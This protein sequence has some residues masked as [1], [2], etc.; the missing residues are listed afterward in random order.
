MQPVNVQRDVRLVALVD[1]EPV[2]RRLPHPG[3]HG[4]LVKRNLGAVALL[5]LA[6]DLQLGIQHLGPFKRDRPDRFDVFLRKQQHAA[7]FRKRG[8]IDPCVHLA[9][10]A[11]PGDPLHIDAVGDLIPRSSCRPLQEIDVQVIPQQLAADGLQKA[12]FR[13]QQRGLRVLP[14]PV[15]VQLNAG[16]VGLDVPAV[17]V[18]HRADDEH[19]RGCRVHPDDL[20]L[21]QDDLPQRVADVLRVHGEHLL[22]LCLFDFSDH[23]A[24]L[25]DR[26]G[27]QRPGFR[28]AHVLAGVRPD[29]ALR[30]GHRDCFHVRL[31]EVAALHD[32][33][34]GGQRCVGALIHPA[35][36][37]LRP[38]PVVRRGCAQSAVACHALPVFAAIAD[39]V[40]GHV[41]PHL[42]PC[43]V[44][45]PDAF[46]QLRV[47]P[48]SLRQSVF[49]LPV[50]HRAQRD[51]VNV[52]RRHRCPED[53]AVV[54]RNRA[55]VRADTQVHV[56]APVF[57]P[58]DV[59]SDR[60]QVDALL[61]EVRCPFAVKLNHCFTTLR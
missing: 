8:R 33:G 39:L 9:G 15:R 26:D 51:A 12:R 23:K 14:A 2:V 58:G 10:V 42:D 41:A 24:L 53:L 36:G 46:G 21:S 25:S 28:F 16:H 45:D 29:V 35:A 11:G 27:R 57:L 43:L 56:P 34:P 59:R 54:K 61:R 6:P 1:I 7:V 20:A 47:Q 48:D 22:V 50:G 40:A 44:A 3:V 60:W 4:V 49:H 38:E 19:Q 18:L 13:I 55:R 32:H 31:V 5:L 37:D 30:S 52:L 17:G